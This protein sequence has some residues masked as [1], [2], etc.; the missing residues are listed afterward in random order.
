MYPRE[1]PN[2]LCGNLAANP[3]LVVTINLTGVFLRMRSAKPR[4]PP[5]LIDRHSIKGGQILQVSRSDEN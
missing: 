4:P 3:R 5:S 1:T 2:N